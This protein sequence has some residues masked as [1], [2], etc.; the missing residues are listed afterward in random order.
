MYFADSELAQALN[1]CLG[2]FVRTGFGCAG[3]DMVQP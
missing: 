2:E 1:R 3:A